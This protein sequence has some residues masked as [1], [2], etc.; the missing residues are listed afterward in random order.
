M[1]KFV[2]DAFLKHAELD[3]SDVRS[4]KNFLHKNKV[5]IIPFEE[6]Q[7]LKNWKE[8]AFQLDGAIAKNKSL[9]NML[10]QAEPWVQ[11]IVEKY[12]YQNLMNDTPIKSQL[13]WIKDLEEITRD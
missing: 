8:I 5:A 1:I 7:D 11:E 12:R 2:T 13:D 3:Y 9:K 10:L 4:T 6:Y